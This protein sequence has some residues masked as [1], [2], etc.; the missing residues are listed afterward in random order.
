MIS[1]S[2]RIAVLFIGLKRSF[3][4][5]YQQYILTNFLNPLITDYG[6]SK[7]DIFVSSDQRLD[8]SGLGEN[9]TVVDQIFSPYPQPPQNSESLNERLYN[10]QIYRLSE[11]FEAFL[12]TNVD[13][14]DFAIKVRPDFLFFRNPLPPIKNWSRTTINCRMR[15][16]PQYLSSLFYSGYLNIGEETVDDQFFIIPQKL[17]DLS[18]KYTKGKKLTGRSYEDWPEAHQTEL[19]HSNGVNCSLLPLN[20]YIHNFRFD[21]YGIILKKHKLIEKMRIGDLLKNN[22]ICQCGYHYVPDY[23][24][25]DQIL[26]AKSITRHPYNDDLFSQLMRH[27]YSVF[28]SEILDKPYY[29]WS[30]PEFSDNVDRI[31]DQKLLNVALDN[32]GLDNDDIKY[33]NSEEYKNHFSL[34]NQSWETVFTFETIFTPTRID[35][36]KK[37]YLLDATI[38]TQTWRNVNCFA[39][40][41][42]ICKNSEI[43]FFVE[44]IKTIR[45]QLIDCQFLIYSDS[46]EVENHLKSSTEHNDLHFVINGDLLESFNDMVASDLFVMS[47]GS[48]L[49]NMVGLLHQ[50]K[51]GVYY[52]QKMVKSDNHISSN[53]FFSQNKKWK[54]DLKEIFK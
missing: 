7:V 50:G 43:D 35:H 20:G 48:N 46:I 22:S 21:P 23:S 15:I 51:Y 17:F 53:C 25:M 10:A 42:H 33:D 44:T 8:F 6:C 39:V 52:D 9:I 5:I 13:G 4:E 18:F 45:N 32:Q 16:Y 24:L 27:I 26:M 2:Y 14:Y 34:P 28:I 54:T 49:S 3:D 36:L 40:A 11:C 47:F 31:F 29:Y 37:N 38:H 1:E 12:K 30:T 41:I 19:W